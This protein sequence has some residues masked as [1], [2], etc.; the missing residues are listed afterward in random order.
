MQT[1]QYV[2]RGVLPSKNA[3]DLE[4]L[5]VENNEELIMLMAKHN[6][7]V[8]DVASLIEVSYNGVI[9]WL[10]K[11][12]PARMPKVAL[13]ALRLSIELKRHAESEKPI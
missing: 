7:S 9:N 5:K 3:W 6:L 4:G 1:Q 13:V 2:A 12:R 8:Q 11:G 10:R